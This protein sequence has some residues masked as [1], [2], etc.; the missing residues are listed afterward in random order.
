MGKMRAVE[1]YAGVGG[2]SIGLASAGM[3]VVTGHATSQLI[4]AIRSAN[5]LYGYSWD[6]AD[7]NRLPAHFVRAGVDLIAGAP[8]TRHC[9]ANGPEGDGERADLTLSFTLLVGAV[10]PEWFLYEDF[11]NARSSQAYQDARLLWKRYGYGLT[12]LPLDASLYG[13]AQQRRRLM[14][15]GRIGE[16]DGFLEQSI[17]RRASPKQKLVSAVLDPR[18]P[19]DA[20]LIERSSYSIRPRNG[21]AHTIHKIRRPAPDLYESVWKVPADV[22]EAGLELRHLSLLQSF[23]RDF[24]WTE[25][26][27]FDFWID[28]SE[29]GRVI[30]SEVPPALAYNVGK[31]IIDLHEGR[32]IPKLPDEF[33]KWIKRHRGIEQ[34][35]ANNIV[36]RVNRARELLGG[37]TFPTGQDE[38]AALE[39][40]A[41]YQ[42]LPANT[43]SE[44][45]NALTD[46][47]TFLEENPGSSTAP[48]ERQPEAKQPSPRQRWSQ[49]RRMNSRSSRRWSYSDLLL[50][51]HSGRSVLRNLNEAASQSYHD[52]DDIHPSEPPMPDDY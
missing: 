18:D 21:D 36:S 19:K 30:V 5:R 43:R 32:D 29:L 7:L 12:E 11:E 31:A 37:R 49:L 28:E 27:D 9:L 24:N 51:P 16:R 52:D 35:S 44:L 26:F 22:N 33:K 14:V 45:R 13:V 39:K 8:Y 47:A 38:V 23:P 3:D 25:L 20:N 46:Y 50:K 41:A 40:N 10:R 1:V 2:L 6:P 4:Q 42:N 34:A 48:A 15:I 17:D